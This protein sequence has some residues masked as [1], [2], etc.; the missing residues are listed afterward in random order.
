MRKRPQVGLNSDLGEGEPVA[1]TRALMRWI[2]AANIACGGHAGTGTTM[3]ACVRAATRAGVQIGAHPGSWSRA[4]KGRRAIG[5]TPDE[6]TL[7]L[8]HQVS[9]LTTIVA[10]E[11]ARLNHIKL[12]GALYHAVEADPDLTRAYLRCV[13]QHW[14]GV[15]VYALA[16]GQVVRDASRFGVPCSA[17]AF[18]DRAYR[19]D[20][21]LVPRS[22]SGSVIDD[23]PAIEMR[24][25]DVL[26]G[27]GITTTDGQRIAMRID[28]LCVHSDTPHA[29]L[30]A[31]RVASLLG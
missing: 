13:A 23:L 9:A 31:K 24:V 11:G 3:L 20:G 18:A 28:T 5:I 26:A 25:R 21:T 30:I 19:R 6:L 10:R 4:D 15:A 7:L 14:P 1:T 27:R 17:E 16:G 29:V 22:R 8:L 12:H 2:T